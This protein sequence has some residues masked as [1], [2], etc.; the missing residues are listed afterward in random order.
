[1]AHLAGKSGYVDTGIAVTGINS[2]T[3]DYTSDTL[4]TTDFADAGVK[5]YIIGC[6][7]W[8]GS[9]GGYKDGAPQTLAGA[10][11]TLKL[12]ES[13]TAYWSSA[14]SGA[15]IT[16]VHSSVSQ[17]G[18]VSVSYDFQGTGTLSHTEA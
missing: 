10:A 16:G 13:A 7:G 15:F 6:S 4:E 11:V 8:S 18:V 3:L 2:W 17:D 5:T 14:A 9:F 12:Y 1:M